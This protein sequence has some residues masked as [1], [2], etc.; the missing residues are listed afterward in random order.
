MPLAPSPALVGQEIH[1][2]IRN[3]DIAQIVELGGVSIP[4]ALDAQK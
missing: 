4:D 3:S 2:F 1:E